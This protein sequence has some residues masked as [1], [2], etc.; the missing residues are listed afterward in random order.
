MQRAAASTM[1]YFSKRFS[2]AVLLASV[3][4]FPAGLVFAQTVP[5][6]IRI[7]VEPANPSIR[8]ITV[9]KR[10]RPIIARDT[11][12][13]VIDTLGS[14]GSPLPCSV[15]LEVTL[16]NSRV[17]HRDADFCAG[18]TF[19]VDVANDG[20]P[21]QIARVVGGSAGISTA[22]ITD[23]SQTSLPQ[24][25]TETATANPDPA[26]SSNETDPQQDSEGD[27]TQWNQ[28]QSEGL[29][30]LEQVETAISTPGADTNA[31]A[32]LSGNLETIVNNSLNRQP[33]TAPA[34]AQPI[35]VT[36]SESRS[37]VTEPGSQIN[38][39]TKMEHTVPQTD[40]RDFLA[41]C[42]TQ[43]GLSS[44]VFQQAPAGLFEGMPQ[45]VRISAGEFSAT[46]NGFGSS[47]NNQYGQSFPEVTLPMTDPLWEALIRES[48]LSVT[49]E[50][51]V[52][53]AVS[54]KGS[55]TPVRL[56]V[57]TCSQ[58][59]QIVSDEAFGLAAEEPNTDLACS[60]IGRAR[61]IEAAR[62]GQIVFRNASRQP[63][64]V[65]WIDY[66][67]GERP[68]A[69]LEP[70]QIL[71]QQTYVSHAWSVR[72]SA[73]Q[74]RGIYVSRN[75]YREVIIRGLST[76]APA[77]AQDPFGN[78]GGF[79]NN[80]IPNGPVP[81]GSIG[82]NQQDFSQQAV[83]RSV[84]DYLCTS[85]VDLNVVFSGGG[86]T[87]TVAEIGYGT[88]TLQRQGGPGVFYYT[89]QGHELKGQIQDA[90]WSRPGVREVFCARR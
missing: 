6:T 74:C 83:G 24:S 19:V 7:N 48:E 43:S 21:G 85:G 70:G 17:L 1:F 64:D 75:P 10:Y 68:Y 39:L 12:G 36:A 33:G 72:D 56:F 23:G 42:M 76:I 37:W 47:A 53:Y 5:E 31:D 35:M 55:A 3:G 32:G 28:N 2:A 80:G 15:K 89:G 88:I 9:N 65:N 69:R 81:P 44:V 40:D 14:D 8:S 29:P 4:V 79:P 51:M 84:A 22:P 27:I 54:L 66:N 26:P 86:Q 20:K 45:S 78:P 71:E 16:E 38:S 87:A 90:V 57:A 82:G 41:S 67:G 77:G 73:G 63:V 59:Q 18:E 30:P 50:G 11:K 25:G 58:P 49:V 52:P 13:V 46:Y 61:S 60:E 34:N 62:A